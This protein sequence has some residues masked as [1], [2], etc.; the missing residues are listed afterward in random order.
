MAQQ[1]GQA[2][3]QPDNITVLQP[4]TSVKPIIGTTPSI[5]SIPPQ[6]ATTLV[7]VAIGFA[8]G[9]WLTN[10]SSTKRSIF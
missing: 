1:N 7:W 4:D 5:I 8:L 3:N 6:I 9:V 10:R 2:A